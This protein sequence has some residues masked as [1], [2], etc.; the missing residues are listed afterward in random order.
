MRAIE[1]MRFKREFNLRTLQDATLIK[2][3]DEYE[4][5]ILV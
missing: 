1:C 3:S 5:S 4:F 2:K